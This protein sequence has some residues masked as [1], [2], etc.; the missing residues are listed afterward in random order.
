MGLSVLASWTWVTIS[1]L[2]LGEF[3][4]LIFSNI[5]LFS[6]FSFQSSYNANISALDIVL[7]FS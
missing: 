2:R 6:F 4:A 1:F 5:F 3:S 7:E